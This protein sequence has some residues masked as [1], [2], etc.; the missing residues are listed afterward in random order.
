ML[1]TY[2]NLTAGGYK[3]EDKYTEEHCQSSRRHGRHKRTHTGEK[4][5]ECN[6]CG[7]ASAHQN[8]LQKHKGTHTG[9][10]TFECNQ[11]GKALTCHSRLKI[12][13][14]IHSGE[15]PHESFVGSCVSNPLVLSQP[16]QREV[17]QLLGKREDQNGATPG[18]A[19][20]R[21]LGSRPLRQLLQCGLI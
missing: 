11:C 19:E 17:P 20:N 2:R 18:L 1:E 14:S 6:Q 4:P 8:N 9:E 21:P 3:W 10:K 15:N 13:K 12:H 16:L 7:K 5:F